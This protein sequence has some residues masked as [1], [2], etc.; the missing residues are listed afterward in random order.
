MSDQEDVDPQLDPQLPIDPAA[1][2]TGQPPTKKAKKPRATKLEMAERAVREKNELRNVIEAKAQ[3]LFAKGLNNAK[4][5]SQ[6]EKLIAKLKRLDEQLPTLE[7]E[8]EDRKEAARIEAEAKAKALE[9][10]KLK[11]ELN[12][13][14]SE[15]AQLGLVEDRLSLQKRF[16]SNNQKH[17]VLWQKVHAL[18]TKRIDDGLL[19]KSDISRAGGK[20]GLVWF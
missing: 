11:D 19:S 20:D 5:K 1:A 14:L 16:E 12:Q 6:H 4:V 7:K 18:Y 10:Q 13:P 2:A 3:V 15:A 8:V 17:D 9:E